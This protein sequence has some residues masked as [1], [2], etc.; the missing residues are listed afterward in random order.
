MNSS[1]IEKRVNEYILLS[2][3]IKHYNEKIDELNANMQKVKSLLF[4]DRSKKY[5]EDVL[6]FL[7]EK[8]NEY[9]EED[10]FNELVSKVKLWSKCYDKYIAVKLSQMSPEQL[11]IFEERME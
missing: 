9:K 1:R 11:A 2:E 8:M 5:I 6:S 4:E 10:S 7:S 3:Q